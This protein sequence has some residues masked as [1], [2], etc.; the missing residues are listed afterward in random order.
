VAAPQLRKFILAGLSAVSMFASVAAAF[1]QVPAPVPALPDSERRTTYSISATTCACAINF[2]LLGDGTD[3]QNWIE[4]FLNGVR[5]NFNDATFGW[6]VTSP[7]GTLSTLARP[8]T[9]AVLTFTAPQTGTIQIVGARRPR[10]TSQFNEGAGVPTRNFNQVLTDIIA[11]QREEWDKTNDVTGRAL[12]SQPGNTIGL[13]PLPSVCASRFLGFDA[14]GLIPLC[15][16]GGPGS[17]N[18]VGPAISTDGDFALFNGATG[19]LLKDAPSTVIQ[20]TTANKVWSGPT[21][22]GAAA[23]GFRALVGADLPAPGASS[24]GGVQSITCSASNWF[25]T[26]S[27]GGVLGCAQPNFNNLLGT[28]AG[29]QIPSSTITSAMIVD[30]TIVDADVSASA[31]IAGSKVTTVSNSVAGVVPALPNDS[32]KFFNG[33]GAYAT[34]PSAGQMIL[35]NTLTASGSATL[36]D[37]TSLTN[38]YSS[39]ELVFLNIVPAT[40]STSCEIQVHAS[41]AFQATGYITSYWGGTAGSTT[42]LTGNPTTFIPCSH[43]TS[44][45]NAAP[46]VNGMIRISTPSA[47]AIHGW[48]GSFNVDTGA[49][50]A[51]LTVAGKWNTSAVIDGFQVL[52]SSGNIA[53]GVV[54]IYGIQ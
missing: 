46:G 37:T 40:T 48:Y 16:A 1:A 10:R 41:A 51:A 6:T 42:P 19:A 3:F 21:S 5:V 20:N 13:L 12:L 23:P 9:N 15:L 45:I 18:V 43:L 2:A 39:Y 7:S 14:T 30:A 35:L 34:P 49:N 36:S 38:T 8:I 50:I 4:V 52:F 31:A 54:K 44:V 24:L 26:L 22:G 32:T 29:A 28:I 17:G 53:S 27:T 33:V 25:N 47:A 11:T